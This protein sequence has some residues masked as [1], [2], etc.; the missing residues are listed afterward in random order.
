MIPCK[1]DLT[2]TPF[3]DTTILTYEI[4][5]PPS[6]NKI[7]INLLDDEYFTIPYVINNIPNSLSGNQLPTQANKNLCIIAI[8]GENVTGT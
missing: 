2:P 8:N 1:L 5:L 6:V 3:H 7:G 4:E